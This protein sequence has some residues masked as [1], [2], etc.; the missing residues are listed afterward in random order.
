MKPKTMI[1]MVVAVSCGLGASYMTSR[2]LA[3]RDHQVEKVTI[4]VAKKA[5]NMGD[6]IKAP[7]D[8]FIEKEVP[9]GEEP[10]LRDCDVDYNLYFCSGRRDWALPHLN[11]ERKFGID[12]H[13]VIA[14]PLFVDADRGDFHLRK[15]SPAFALGIEPIELEAIGLSP[16]HPF[17]PLRLSPR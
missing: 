12:R 4:L 6:T 8:W 9:K 1:L 2:L 10:R 11:A 14:D 16:D 17:I 5:L 15:E 3:D 13:S 7:D